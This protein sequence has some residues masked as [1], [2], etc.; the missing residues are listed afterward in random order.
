MHM[1][2]E[3]LACLMGDEPIGCF[4]YEWEDPDTLGFVHIGTFN[5][6]K[7]PNS[8][9]ADTL[10]KIGPL[11]LAMQER[12]RDLAIKLTELVNDIYTTTPDQYNGKF[13]AVPDPEGERPE[14]SDGL[15]ITLHGDRLVLGPWVETDHWKVAPD[16]GSVDLLF[17]RQPDRWVICLTTEFGG[18]NDL[19]IYVLDDKR[20][21][22]TGDSDREILVDANRR[23]QGHRDFHLLEGSPGTPVDPVPTHRVLDYGPGPEDEVNEFILFCGSEMGADAECKR[24]N[25]QDTT[26]RRTNG[27]TRYGVQAIPDVKL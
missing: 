3:K 18:D 1:I 14:Y 27:R 4:F 25:N 16:D 5:D 15:P 20:I 10:I 24:L 7:D 12:A 22:I 9:E 2:F 6:P 11:N 26:N 17:E 19:M 8:G 21:A 23:F 13:Y